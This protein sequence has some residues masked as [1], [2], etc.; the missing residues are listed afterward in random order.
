MIS[1]L[2]VDDMAS[3]RTI[4]SM[5]LDDYFKEINIYEAATAK[6]ALDF[7]SK[8]KVNIIL[9][10]IEMPEMNGFDFV[11]ELK[12]H[13]RTKHIPIIFVSSHSLEEYSKNTKDIKG[14]DFIHKPV[15]KDILV[16]KILNY[17]NMYEVIEKK[18]A[19]VEENII[20]SEVDL[21]GVIT[22]ASQAFCNISGYSKE[23][24]IGQ[25]HNIVR[26]PDMKSETFKELWS[27]VQEGKT[28]TG[29][30]TNLKKGGKDNYTVKATVFPLY[31]NGKI[32]GYGSERQDI[33]KEIEARNDFE[34]ILNAGL[35]IVLVSSG[36]KL[37][38]A[39]KVL[40]TDYG[41]KD[42]EDFK[43][44][45]DC[46]CDLFIEKDV[47]HLKKYMGDQTWVE[48]IK[49]RPDEI[50]EAYMIDVHKKERVFRV[51]YRGLLKD[52]QDIIILDDITEIKEQTNLL[53]K[54][55]KFAAMGEMIGMIAHQWRQPLS[56]MNALMIKLNLKR[57][58]KQLD[59]ITWKES[60]AKHSELTTYMTTTIDDFKNFF[61]DSNE[62]HKVKVSEITEKPYRLVEGLLKKQNVTFEVIYEDES[63]KDE[64]YFIS[65]SKLDQVFMN[66]YKNSLDEFISKA[67]D[68]GS[69]KI[70]CIKVPKALI[71]H[72]YDN[73]GGIPSNIIE[74]IFDPYFSTKADNGTGIGL[75]MTKMIVE[76]HI[77]GKIDVYNYGDGACFSI[78]IPVEEI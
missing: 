1:I 46:V 33:S 55:S 74:R 53:F 48:Y 35:S 17:V 47:P 43:S 37:L 34:K 50:H 24:L 28:W 29:T 76:N 14:F 9:S 66:L 41:F 71:Y 25:P 65:S 58:L 13:I 30:V 52:S 44:Q 77:H 12:Q 69:I 11:R 68:N 32:Y 56:A 15:D 21:D 7:I 3:N 78:A 26:H 49:E 2:L 45:H 61:K 64:L 51:T 38:K 18:S 54:Q 23:E 75:Y 67:Q 73:A 4:I 72:V 42:F 36:M 62:K 59:D 57:K 39:N 60:Y 6:D 31:N 27:T 70:T 19:L 10:D 20:Y 8:N 40:F 5:M 16:S 63:L 22:S